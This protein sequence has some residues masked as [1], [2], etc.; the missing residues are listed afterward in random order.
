M[1]TLCYYCMTPT[2]E[3]GVCKVCGKPAVAVSD[4]DVGV[5]APGTELDSGSVVVGTKIGRGG[6]GITYRALDRET[7]QKVALKEFMPTHLVNRGRD[8]RTIQV[9]DGMEDT[10]NAARRGFMREAKVLHELRRHPHI[11]NVLFTIEENNTA[12]Y[13]M[14]LLNGVN[15]SQWVRQR[16]KKIPAKEACEILLP[17]MD[18]LVYCHDK[19]VL[20]RDIS[21]DNIFME[22]TGNGNVCA[23]LIDFGAAYVAIEN[24]THT[25]PSVRKQ[26]YSPLEQM[27]TDR[28]EQGSWS[29]V[30]SLAATLFYLITGTPPTSALDIAAGTAVMHPPSAYQVNIPNAAEK[31]LMHALAQNVSERI[32]TV[33]EF[34]TAICNALGVPWQEILRRDERSG[35]TLIDTNH[36]EEPATGTSTTGGSVLRVE[37]V[38]SESVPSSAH[39]HEE[40]PA[41]PQAPPQYW[42]RALIAGVQYLTFYGL[43]Y[44]AFGPAGL[45]VGYAAFMLFQFLLVSAGS[46]GTIGMN[47]DHLTFRYGSEPPGTGPAMIFALW[48]ASPLGLLDGLMLVSGKEALADRLSGLSAVSTSAQA[49]NAG[50]QAKPAP[51]PRSEPAKEQKPP[52]KK[53]ASQ[54]QASPVQEDATHGSAFIVCLQGPMKGKRFAVHVGDTAGRNPD[55][56]QILLGSEDPTVSKQHCR[57]IRAR[58]GKWGL[59]NLS[60]NGTG[61]DGTLILEKNGTPQVLHN[62]TMIQ[63]GMSTYQF[64]IK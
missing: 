11:V 47:A 3:N 42:K 40:P 58:N 26:Y 56:S 60:G 50:G 5:L 28:N 25:F 35:V 16:G 61:I 64:R 37:P 9:L 30:Y 6:F 33:S 10:F 12:Y 46:H 29:D 32:Q 59:T 23:K 48:N 39:P 49:G 24:F 20:H 1:S 17:V 63:I 15:L 18:A 2:V 36:P 51:V 62:G 55:V 8:G 31:V 34:R 57:F 14:E 43:G 41:I 22:N 27:N 45:A 53:A 44:L 7:G 21:P 4:K 13:G 54:E 52:Q 38:P 19:G